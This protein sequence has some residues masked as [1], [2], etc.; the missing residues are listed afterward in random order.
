MKILLVSHKYP[1]HAIGGVEVYTS[2]LARALGERH[3]VAVFFRH[4]EEKGPLVSD[5]EADQ[6]GLL[7]VQ[8]SHRPSGWRASVAGEFFGTFLN[9][10]I[11]DRFRRLLGEFQ[12]DLIHFQHV[13]GLS[14]RL[15][16]IAADTEKPVLLTLHDYWFICANSQLIWP[17]GQVCRGKA[18]G[19]NCVRCAAA[20]RFP[21]RLAGAIRP[22]AAPVF[23]YRDRVVRQAALKADRFVS[24]SHFLADRYVASGFPAGQFEVLENGIDVAQIQA[25]DRKPYG[26]PLRVTYLGSLAWQKGVHVL[27][28]AFRALPPGVARL[29]IWGDPS[30]FPAYA[31][32]LREQLAGCDGQLMGPVPNERVGKVLADSDV[33]VVPSLWYENS[34]VV[35]QEGR[36]AGI[37][38]VASGHGALPE[39]VRDGAEGLHFPP[40]DA[41]A[42]AR[43]LE[44]LASEPEHL[45]RL[46]Q[47]LSPAMDAV[48]HTRALE[49]I[50]GRVRAEKTKGS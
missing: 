44:R 33:L 50:Y 25:F 36:A 34:P 41:I 46:G 40:G 6:D 31:E 49:E 48:D 27:A 17:D 42:L 10:Q 18:A 7:R 43:T 5:R 47:G 11:E 16:P 37:P 24:P 28:E 3:S 45:Q 29:R 13:M 26:G 22:L 30:V 12:P 9:R 39:K 35:I 23:L 8:V 1:P 20:A 21:T 15:L 2:R 4:D 19:M 32:R 14:A 38:I